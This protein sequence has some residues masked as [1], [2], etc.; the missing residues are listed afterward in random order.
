MAIVAATGVDVELRERKFWRFEDAEA[1]ARARE[2][3]PSST[4]GEAGL[5]G[6]ITETAAPDSQVEVQSEHPDDEVE[7]R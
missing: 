7:G 1:A 3:P 5:V 2:N 4:D 6:R